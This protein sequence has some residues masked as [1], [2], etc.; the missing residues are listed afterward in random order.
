MIDNLPAGKKHL[1]KVREYPV[2]YLWYGKHAYEPLEQI[3]DLY[4]DYFLWMLEKFQ[5]V[6]TSQ[7]TF[8]QKK[9]QVDIP[10][11][12]VENVPPYVYV[13]KDPPELYEALCKFPRPE[14]SQVLHQYRVPHPENIPHKR[15]RTHRKPNPKQD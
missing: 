6:T 2:A 3:M 1:A 14:L 11:E 4:P 15:T 9:Y 10:P 8:F 13:R 5:N 12:A 7:A